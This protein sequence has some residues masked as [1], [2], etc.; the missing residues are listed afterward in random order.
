MQEIAK[1]RL[2]ETAHI[3]AYGKCHGV[4]TVHEENRYVVDVN[5]SYGYGT[6]ITTIIIYFSWFLFNT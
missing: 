6:V 3:D 2:R 1:F 4:F 5:T